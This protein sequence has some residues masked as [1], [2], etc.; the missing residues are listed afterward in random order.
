MN[1]EQAIAYFEETER[2]CAGLSIDW[3]RGMT[4]SGEG[5]LA[6]LIPQQDL[7]PVLT[8]DA[9]AD[10]RDIAFVVEAPARIRFLVNL[11]RSLKR[12]LDAHEA[13]PAEPEKQ[14]SLAQ[15]CGRLCNDRAFQRW[16][17]EVH[18]LDHSWDSQRAAT[19]VRSLLAITSRTD[20]DTDAEAAKRW[21][22]L[23]RDFYIWR[24]RS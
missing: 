11:V 19:K 9:Y 16:L 24:K 20:L 6:R 3:Q 13:P 21:Q 23:R 15:D 10:A 18:G 5:I 22:Q 14:K 1:R 8:F 2:M 4:P 7:E 12:R 17:H